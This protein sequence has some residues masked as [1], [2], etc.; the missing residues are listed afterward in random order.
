MLT[1]QF[2]WNK[3]S[4]LVS[5]SSAI[6]VY[7]FAKPAKDKAWYIGYLRKSKKSKSLQE[8]L[9]EEMDNISFRETE[10][11]LKQL[12]ILHFA[13]KL[14]EAQFLS[15]Y[16][17][18]FDK[19][20]K[21]FS[22]MRLIYFV[23]FSYWNKKHLNG[24][25]KLKRKQAFIGSMLMIMSEMGNYFRY[26]MLNRLE[27]VLIDSNIDLNQ[28]SP[29]AKYLLKHNG[30]YYIFETFGWSGWLLLNSY[31]YASVS[32]L[33]MTIGTILPKSINGY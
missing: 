18:D 22:F 17:P 30:L 12:F 33:F 2:D 5:Y 10:L 25:L 23:G 28:L 14:I 21:I 26:F 15:K 11:M 7:L 27:N 29:K 8:E 31:S 20:P 13:R 4:S 16:C 32:W 3:A 24:S 6:L 9:D 19:Q 1:T